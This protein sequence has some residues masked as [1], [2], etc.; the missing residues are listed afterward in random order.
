MC[1]HT[2]GSTKACLVTQAFLRHHSTGQPYHN[3]ANGSGLLGGVNLHD[4]RRGTGQWLIREGCGRTLFLSL[5]L[6]VGVIASS[7]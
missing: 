2:T 6:S 3:L 7:Q 5:H 4:K 1:T